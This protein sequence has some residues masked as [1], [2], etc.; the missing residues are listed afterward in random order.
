[1]IWWRQE[2]RR[3]YP[4]LTL[5]R[6]LNAIQNLLNQTLKW[7]NIIY[8][9]DF[10]FLYQNYYY[11]YSFQTSHQC[12]VYNR[13]IHITHVVPWIGSINAHKSFPAMKENKW[14]IASMSY[15]AYPN[16]WIN[17]WDMHQ[18]PTPKVNFIYNEPAHN[19]LTPGSKAFASKKQE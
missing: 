14:L 11:Y 2:S 8:C 3:I 15:S 5:L 6:S 12:N 7:R 16:H 1:M 18:M 13:Y 9:Y 19:R 17:I 4:C 10:F